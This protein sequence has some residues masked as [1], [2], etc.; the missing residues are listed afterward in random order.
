MNPTIWVSNKTKIFSCNRNSEMSLW[1]ILVLTLTQ[2]WVLI[3]TYFCGCPKHINRSSQVGR[4]AGRQA[5][6]RQAGRQAENLTNLV[7]I[8]STSSFS[9]F[10][11]LSREI[12]NESSRQFH[13]WALKY[14]VVG[15]A[16]VYLC[17]CSLYCACVEWTSATWTDVKIVI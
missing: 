9:S 17:A 10:R 16:C 15:C 3:N 12:S 7:S 4:W 2:Y 13:L 8:L 5:D 1:I 11:I 14:F 6:L